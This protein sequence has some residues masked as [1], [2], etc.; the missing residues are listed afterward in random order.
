[1]KQMLITVL[2]LAALAAAGCGKERQA[3]ELIFWHT[4]AQQN[5]KLL[6]EIVDEYNATDPPMK[7]ALRYAGTYTTLFRKVRATIGTR[8]VPDLIVAYESMVAEYIELG[9]VVALDEYINDPKLGLSKESLDDIVPS[10]LANNRYPA[11]GD[12]YYTFPFTKSILM[13]Y[14]NK[15]LLKR[16][17][18]TAPP[19]TWKEFTQQCLAVKKLGKRGYALSVDASTVDAFVMSYGGQLLSDDRKRALFDQPPALAA[20]TLIYNLAKAGAA[21]QVDRRSYGDRKDF[22]SQQCA[23]IIRSSTTRPFLQR[24]IRGKFDWDMCIIPH[25]EGHKPVTVMFGA[26]IAVMKTTPERQRA[27]WCFVKYFCSKNVTAKWATGTGYLPVRGSAAGTKLVQ[28]FFARRLQNR[29]AFDT[30]PHARPEP[31]AAG[32]QGVR[33][34]IELAESD[35][36][37]GRI[38]PEQIAK[39]LAKKA[40]AALEE[41]RE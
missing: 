6:Q 38:P 26:N 39:D 12:K 8:G 17:G 37:R 15:D 27:A 7:V 40:N 25:G 33:N 10:I 3:D 1:M 5:A 19:A 11:Y 16:A 28:D 35:A 13:M 29:R 31:G 9:A 24:D 20:F 41:A 32:W 14:R 23:F 21:Y 18:F 2:C 30:L 36:V 22:A 4:Q 34:H